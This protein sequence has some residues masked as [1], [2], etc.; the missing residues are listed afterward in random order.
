MT[1]FL[2]PDRLA[3]ARALSREVMPPAELSRSSFAGPDEIARLYA[4]LDL[5]TPETNPRTARLL[6]AGRKQ[7]AKKVIEEAGEVAL[8]A[9]R[10]RAPATVR[11]SADL[12]YHLTVLWHACGIS[13]DEIWAEMQRRA[14]RLGLAEKLPKTAKAELS[15]HQPLPD[16][17]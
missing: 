17:A 11:E 3:P 12:L 5:V 1:L 4:A 9:A 7:A 10:H 16:Q 2:N 8:E 6:K 15:S 13:P 14:D